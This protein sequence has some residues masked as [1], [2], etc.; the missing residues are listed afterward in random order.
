MR[1]DDL[2]IATALHN[3]V[4]EWKH[5]P[6]DVTTRLGTFNPTVMIKAI[7]IWRGGVTSIQPLLRLTTSNAIADLAQGECFLHLTGHTLGNCSSCLRC[8]AQVRAVDFD[9]ALTN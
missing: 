5:S 7:I 1:D 2:H 3:F 8:T 4:N 6:R 9:F